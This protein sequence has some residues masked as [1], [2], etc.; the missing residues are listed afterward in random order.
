MGPCWVRRSHVF[1]RDSIISNV[2]AAVNRILRDSMEFYSCSGPELIWEGGDPAVPQMAGSCAVSCAEEDKHCMWCRW[3]NVVKSAGRSQKP[4]NAG[5]SLRG[6]SSTMPR[7]SR[8]T[9]PDS[10][11]SLRRCKLLWLK[12]LTVE[13]PLRGCV[14]GWS[15][16]GKT[17][18]ELR[19]YWKRYVV[20]AREP[21]T[22]QYHYECVVVTR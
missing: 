11:G 2:I 6:Q 15:V 3:A 21:V 14:R 13:V 9:P 10:K 19:K 12:M 5:I 7:G 18:T 1:F 4:I 8:D 17:P 22:A 20:S 16:L